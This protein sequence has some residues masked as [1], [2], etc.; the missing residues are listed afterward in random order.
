MHSLR[1]YAEKLERE[2]KAL[3]EDPNSV[4][5]QF[6]SQYQELYSQ[7]SRLSVLT[8]CLLDKLQEEEKFGVVLTKAEMEA[9]KDQRI[10]IKWE[11]P[12][13]VNKPE[14]ADQYIFSFTLDPEPKNL[15]AIVKPTEI[16]NSTE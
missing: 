16:P 3:K 5:S 7:N 9:F 14:N 1:E 8:A 10:N 4:V 6:I 13:G 2:N 15:Q 12:E 11:L